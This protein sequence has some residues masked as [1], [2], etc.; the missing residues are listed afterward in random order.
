MSSP[1]RRANQNPRSNHFS[2]RSKRYEARDENHRSIARPI[3]SRRVRAT[4]AG[5]DHS[6]RFRESKR[7][8]GQVAPKVFPLQ[9]S[10]LQEYELL[11]NRKWHEPHRAAVR[12][13]DNRAAT[14]TRCR[15]RSGAL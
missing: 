6:D 9:F 10:I 3:D 8:G 1:N 13:N 4:K 12:R 7:N 2:R 11:M 15:K 14:S 5:A